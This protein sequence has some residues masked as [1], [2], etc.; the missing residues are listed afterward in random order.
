[1]S[2]TQYQEIIEFWFNE[3]SPEQWWSANEGL[4]LLITS[5][6]KALHQSAIQG[7]L[8]AWREY[9]LG[10]LAEVIILDQ[11]SRN[12]YRGK[13]QAF[14]YDGM[15]L[16]LAQEAVNQHIDSQLE[17]VERSFL[18]M[19]YMHSESLMIHEEA[20]RL[21]EKNN[22]TSNLT[23]EIQHRDIIAQFGRYP[24]RNEVLG[25][26]STEAEIEFLKQPGSSF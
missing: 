26:K 14:A 13:A 2:D 18:Y 1:M 7:E 4:D 22:I 23:F 24:H 19:P 12:I 21:F 25:R 15:A 20:I 17:P 3:L 10:R 6:Y 8:Y 16:T 5:R 9:A 11:F